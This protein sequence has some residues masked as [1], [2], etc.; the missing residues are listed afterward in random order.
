MNWRAV[1]HWLKVVFVELLTTYRQATR[2]PKKQDN[3]EQDNFPLK[4][5]YQRTAVA[6]LQDELLLLSK[7]VIPIAQPERRAVEE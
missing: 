6:G 5:T 2:P 3:D 7:A 4:V 1:A